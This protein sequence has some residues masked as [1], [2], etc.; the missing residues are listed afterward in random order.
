MISAHSLPRDD[1]FCVSVQP[2]LNVL[3]FNFS[4]EKMSS[5][6]IRVD[7]IDLK[8]TNRVVLG[9]ADDEEGFSPQDYLQKITFVTNAFR[10]IGMVEMKPKGSVSLMEGFY[11]FNLNG[12]IG[13]FILNELVTDQLA[14]IPPAW[15][16]S[17]S[18]LLAKIS[19]RFILILF[20]VLF[21]GLFACARTT[22]EETCRFTS[23]HCRFQFG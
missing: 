6:P 16:E 15:L 4:S 20:Q 10:I 19:V 14:S 2:R 3:D 18:H 13:T 12:G 11:S 22:R 21:G 1:L 7:L 5:K 23:L 9:G 8:Q 17:K